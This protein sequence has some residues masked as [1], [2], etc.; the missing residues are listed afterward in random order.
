MAP[1]GRRLPLL[2]LVVVVG[3]LAAS[4]AANAHYVANSGDHTYFKI[5]NSWKLYSQDQLI[6]AGGLSDTAKSAARSSSWQVAFDS[7]P[8]PSIKHLGDPGSKH[9]SGVAIVQRL[10]FSD[11]DSLSLQALRNSFFQIDTAVQNNAARV[12]VYE[13]RNLSGGFHGFHLV[14]ELD[15]SGKT[16]TVDQST[17][18][19]PNLSKIYALVLTCESKC[20][21]K[22]KGRIDGIVGSWTVRSG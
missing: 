7:S 19:N 11:A 6:N 8:K 16:L 4:C 3:W 5:P 22:F 1:H 15:L 10:S 12:L 18:V 13:P 9:P 2:A 21:S 17:V 20:Y 14:A